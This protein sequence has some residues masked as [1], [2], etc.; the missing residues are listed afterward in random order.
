MRSSRWRSWTRPTSLAPMLMPLALVRDT[1]TRPRVSTS[2]AFSPHL[3]DLSLSVQ[4]LR[5]KSPGGVAGRDERRQQ[6]TRF[7]RG[8][9][10]RHGQSDAR[11]HR[12]NTWGESGAREGGGGEGEAG[13]G[14]GG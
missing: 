10:R 1:V 3:T 8:G 5:P 6:C 11:G 12:A 2:S 7:R 13:A 9:R 14:A 4:G